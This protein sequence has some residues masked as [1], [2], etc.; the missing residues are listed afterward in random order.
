MAHEYAVIAVLIEIDFTIDVDQAPCKIDQITQLGCRPHLQRG[1]CDF[2]QGQSVFSPC[3]R[4]LIVILAYETRAIFTETLCGQLQLPVRHTAAAVE[5]Q[6]DD[7]QVSQ[8]VGMRR[9]VQ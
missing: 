8:L 9:V 4:D 1:K 6:C 3:I 2:H 7:E 5:N